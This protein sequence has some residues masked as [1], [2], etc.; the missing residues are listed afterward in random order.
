[1]QAKLTLKLQERVIRRAKRYARAN[2]RS[3]SKMVESYFR[4]VTQKKEPQEPL[5]PI[6]SSLAGILNSTG[7]RDGKAEYLEHLRKK[8]S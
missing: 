4:S 7:G 1:M 5:S 8:Y 3:L 6:T 2:H